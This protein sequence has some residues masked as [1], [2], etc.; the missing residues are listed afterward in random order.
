[1]GWVATESDATKEALIKLQILHQSEVSHD[2]IWPLIQARAYEL[3]SARGG[4]SG[5]A[6]NDWLQ[7][8]R[9]IDQHFGT[10]GLEAQ[11]VY[12]ELRKVPK[13]LRA[14]LIHPAPRTSGSSPN[15]SQI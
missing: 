9:E 5:H 11:A 3:F 12:S 8:E 15:Y 2:E 14:A 6:L 10:Q 4:E 13:A 1:M 7:A